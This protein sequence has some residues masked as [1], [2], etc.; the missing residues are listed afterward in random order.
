MK[1]VLLC[2]IIMIMLLGVGCSNGESVGKN[3][4]SLI[5]STVEDLVKT[6]AKLISSNADFINGTIKGDTLLKICA[7]VEVDLSEVENN[8]K[9]YNSSIK[10]ERV[11]D[12]LYLVSNSIDSMEKIIDYSKELSKN[13]WSDYRD[14]INYENEVFGNNLF[15]LKEILEKNFNE[16]K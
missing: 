5:I 14:K 2:L 10:D 3:E 8:Y 11:K 15:K 9:K 6:N 7:E 13:K 12:V 16:L 4:L 1:K